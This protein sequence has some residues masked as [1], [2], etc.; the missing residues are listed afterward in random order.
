MISPRR[1]VWRTFERL[2]DRSHPLQQLTRVLGACTFSLLMLLIGA[3]ALIFVPQG[4]DVLRRLVE[5]GDRGFWHDPLPLLSFFAAVLAWA[6]SCWYWARFILRQRMPDNPLD[7]ERLR[8]LV[9]AVPRWLGTLAVGSVAFALLR[10]SL[11]PGNLNDERAVGRLI[12]LFL[13][14]AVLTAGFVAFVRGRRHWIERAHL[15]LSAVDPERSRIRP[16]ARVQRRLGRRLDRFVRRGDGIDPY[17]QQDWDQMPPATRLAAWV[18]VVATFGFLV[19]YTLFPVAIAPLLGTAAILLFAGSAFVF[20][21]TT[22]LFVSRRFRVPVLFLVMLFSILFSFWNDNHR[23]RT[24]RAGTQPP[25]RPEIR[26]AFRRWHAPPDDGPFFLVASEGGG[27]RAAYWTALVL[28]EIQD[29]DSRFAGRLFAISG[30]S[31]GSLG[32]AVFTALLADRA[33]HREGGSGVDVPCPDLR[34]C[35][36]DVLSRDFLSPVMAKMIAPDFLQRALPVG[37]RMLD[38]SR[39]LEGAWETAWR[40]VVGT[41]TFRRP[42]LQLGWDAGRLPSLVL[43]STH[44]ES[45]RRILTSN[46]DW[47]GEDFPD[48][49]DLHALLGADMPLSTAVHNSARF[50]WV[51]PAGTI[52]GREGTVGHLVDGGYFENS[53]AATAHEI[54]EAALASCRTGCAQEDELVRADCVAACRSRVRSAAHV[55]YIRNSPDAGSDTRIDPARV[56]ESVHRGMV[57]SISPARALF[58][59]RVARGTHAVSSL[60]SAVEGRFFEFGLCSSVWR[61]GSDGRRARRPVSIPLGWQLSEGTRGVIESQLD[62]GC[63]GADNPAALQG[64]LDVLE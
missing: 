32:G 55:I 20:L 44:V 62:D 54:L 48:A 5:W 34:P 40:R 38:R 10:A 2:D 50:T 29:R 22:A 9:I 64:I 24:V 63:D 6:T 45:G 47:G 19:A 1:L 8:P 16:L 57:E 17:G 12:A 7:V 33:R 58:M 61:A 14:C 37:I 21:G 46:L 52:R 56:R 11:S 42:F 36:R 23:I 59:T 13:I 53:G 27:I 49:Y 35:V 28:A 25:A 3:T 51:S 39:A 4:Q 60:R 18:S 30:V 31:G 26:E 43:N 15:R 41:D